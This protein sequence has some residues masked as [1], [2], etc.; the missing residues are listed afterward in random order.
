MLIG[1]IGIK[2]LE[3]IEITASQ[4]GEF[5]YTRPSKDSALLIK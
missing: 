5:M 2:V 4:D 1:A 3:L